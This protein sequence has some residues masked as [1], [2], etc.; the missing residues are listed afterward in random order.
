MSNS[1]RASAI[2]VR[3]PARSTAAVS[4][5]RAASSA[6]SALAPK[7]PPTPGRARRV[8]SAAPY[9]RSRW[10]I[11]APR[12]SPSSPESRSASVTKNNA[13]SCSLPLKS[14]GLIEL[15]HHNLAKGGRLRIRRCIGEFLRNHAKNAGLAASPPSDDCDH[16]PVRRPIHADL[17]R[18]QRREWPTAQPIILPP[19]RTVAVHL[20]PRA[21]LRSVTGRSRHDEHCGTR[22][23]A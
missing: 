16:Q 20:V 12:S 18:D 2:A 19:D 10:A 5:R 15:D 3:C 4:K 8:P 21:R 14:H 1:R 17:P 23:G 9:R 22:D 11:L 6:R 7:T 13:V